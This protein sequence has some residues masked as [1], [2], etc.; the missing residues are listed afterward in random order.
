MRV[1]ILTTIVF[2]ITAS[3]IRPQRR[4]DDPCFV[5][6]LLCDEVGYAA[7]CGPTDFA[8][9]D[10]SGN[11]FFRPMHPRTSLRVSHL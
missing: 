1:L 11:W 9:C 10:E 4:S 6:G 5:I 3:S 7:C 8:I 2:I